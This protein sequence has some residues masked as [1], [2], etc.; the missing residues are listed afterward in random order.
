MAVVRVEIPGGRVYGM[1]LEEDR[2][3]SH[4][5]LDMS[6]LLRPQVLPF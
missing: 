6:S 1:W 5:Q 4:P 2:P 3:S